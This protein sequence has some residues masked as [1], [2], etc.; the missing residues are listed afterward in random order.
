MTTCG[1][2]GEAEAE[3]LAIEVRAGLVLGEE[4][5]YYHLPI[6]T[7]QAQSAH[8]RRVAIEAVV[9][10]GIAGLR[11]LRGELGILLEAIVRHAMGTRTIYM[12]DTPPHPVGPVGSVKGWLSRSYAINLPLLP[13][14]TPEVPDP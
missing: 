11:P 2:D 10:E 7:R 3:L 12:T 14:D 9:F 13:L 8:V 1:G 4:R 6:W 5:V